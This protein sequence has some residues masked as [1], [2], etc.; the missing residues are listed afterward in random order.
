MVLIDFLTYNHNYDD[1]VLNQLIDKASA[2]WANI[3][4]KDNWLQ[5]IRGGMNE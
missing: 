1:V 3:E 2:S 4:N 5:D